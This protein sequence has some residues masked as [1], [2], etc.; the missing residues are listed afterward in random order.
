M[1]GSAIATIVELS[2]MSIVASAAVAT[3]ARSGGQSTGAA[4]IRLLGSFGGA[5]ALRKRLQQV[6]RDRSV[7]LHERAEVP[8]R[9]PPAHE[10]RARRHRRRAHALVDHRELAERVARAEAR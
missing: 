4:F 7:V 3:T 8:I 5:N 9:Q 6:P 10:V 2:G 1:S